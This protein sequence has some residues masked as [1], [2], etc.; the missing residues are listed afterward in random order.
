[1]SEFSSSHE[2]GDDDDNIVSIEEYLSNHEDESLDPTEL[3]DEE[4]VEQFLSQ[5]SHP[6][7]YRPSGELGEYI[8]R[9]IK[10]RSNDGLSNQDQAWRDR[11]LE[12]M[13]DIDL[14]DEGD[15]E[16]LLASDPILS[17][18]YQRLSTT[19]TKSKEF[20]EERAALILLREVRAGSFL[21]NETT[22]TGDAR[23]LSLI[24]RLIASEN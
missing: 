9:I 3:A 13:V 24:D 16:V 2:M 15:L 6:S 12:L 5:L 21:R 20:A 10:A 1:M 18:I 11:M 14:M 17:M 22:S 4:V 8:Q 23:W 7:A 19:R